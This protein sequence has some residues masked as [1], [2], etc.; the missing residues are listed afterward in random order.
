M[1]LRL[2]LTLFYTLLVALFLGASGLGLYLLLSRSLH[3]GLDRSL[4]EAADL[5]GRLV[6]RE[7]GTLAFDQDEQL[8]AGLVALLLGPQGQRLDSLGR[9]P[10]ELP[11][12]SEGI[13][14]WDDLRVLVQP[15]PEGSLVVLRDAEPVED[16]LES[17]G[18]SFFLLDPLAVLAAAVLGYALAAQALRP[19]DKLTRDA[20]S[21]AQR[22]AWRETLPEP[23]RKDELWR[24]AR[25]TNT[26]LGALAQVIEAERRF[27]ADAAHELRTPLTVLRGRLEQALERAQDAKSRAGLEQA[28]ARQR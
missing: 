11:T 28:R 20:Y 25:A 27:T 18:E 2:R 3:A 10:D 12:L 1:T 22:R 8:R 9:V 13:S 21:L 17:F 14:S 6:E 15:L 5:L 7:D 26:L 23:E 24:L 16:S 4:R 19:V